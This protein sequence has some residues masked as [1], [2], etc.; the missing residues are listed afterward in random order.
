[1]EDYGNR[2]VFAGL[3]SRPVRAGVL[4]FTAK[5]HRAL[6]FTL[7]ADANKRTLT[8][9]IVLPNVPARSAMYREYRDFVASHGSPSL[10]AHRRTDTRKARVACRSRRGNVSLV[11]TLAGD[12]YVY[13]AQRLIHLVHETF[14]FFLT[15]GQYYQYRVE[16]LGDDP[17]WI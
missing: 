5:W 12:D 14:L 8:I 6:V 11:M 1:M 16:Q 10:P 3:S 17:D 4:A 15:E 13:G 2:G 9:P 7:I